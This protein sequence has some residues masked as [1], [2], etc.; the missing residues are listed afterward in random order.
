L[1]FTDP[2]FWFFALAAVLIVGLA[3][4]GFVGM[5]VLGTPLMALAVPP[6]RA[7]AIL[8]PILIIQDMV[9]VW[10]YRKTWDRHVV[11]VMLPGAVIGIFLGYMFAAML[12]ERW[13]LAALGFIA[14]VFSMHRLWL[15]KGGRIV[16]AHIMPDWVGVLCGVGS[17]LASQIAHAGGP[18]YQIWVFPRQLPR[19]TLVGT[20]MVLFAS[21]NLIKVPAYIALGQFTTT[22]LITTAALV[23]FA[24]GAT[25][26]GIHLVR[27]IP[28]ARFYTL[29]YWLTILIGCKLLWDAYTWHGS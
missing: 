17:G 16:A 22:N 4:G 27:T 2:W 8:L 18:P 13:V 15:E 24:I 29:I 6:V 5:G 19:D 7:A 1:V 14:V 20:T 9:A 21:V 3:K 10:S 11:A 26:A 25:L 23:P 28:S 12:P